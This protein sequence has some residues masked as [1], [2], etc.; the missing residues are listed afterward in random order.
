MPHQKLSKN[1]K[2]KRIMGQVLQ[3]N[4]LQTGQD[5]MGDSIESGQPDSSA[6]S[7]GEETDDE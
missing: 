3:M 2:V 6:S 1:D 4:T 7:E 5:E